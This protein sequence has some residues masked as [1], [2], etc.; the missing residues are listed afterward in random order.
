M[1]LPGTMRCYDTRNAGKLRV[2]RKTPLSP[3]YA[4]KSRLKI[5][6]TGLSRS[7]VGPVPSPVISI[8]IVYG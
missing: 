8:F 5:P 3:L 4:G 7:V 2:C 6:K 1:R